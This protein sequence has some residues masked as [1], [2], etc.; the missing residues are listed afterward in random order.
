MDILLISNK[1]ACR[2]RIAQELLHTFGRGMNISTA[3][4][5]EG[6]CVPDV[7]CDVMEQNG[8]GISRKKPSGVGAYAHRSWD[9]VVTLCKEAEEELSFL[10]LEKSFEASSTCTPQW[11]SCKRYATDCHA[12][13]TSG[14]LICP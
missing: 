4:V 12:G 1:D 13:G 6:N 7:V 5:M 2:S 14:N 10:T 9:Y 3:G 8:Y 11:L